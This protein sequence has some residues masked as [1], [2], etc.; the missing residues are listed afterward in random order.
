MTSGREQPAGEQPWGQ[1]HSGAAE[2]DQLLPVQSSVRTST[3][4]P[5]P[6]PAQLTVPAP[7]E[8][9]PLLLGYGRPDTTEKLIIL[10]TI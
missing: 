6:G 7:G 9:P 5:E 3:A 2:E 8:P 4:H 1:D 10:V